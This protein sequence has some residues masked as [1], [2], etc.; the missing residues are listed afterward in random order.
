MAATPVLGRVLSAMVTPMHPDGSLDLQAAARL[1]SHLVDAGHDG[2]VVSGTTG[3]SPTTTDDEKV[4]L[5]RAVVEAVGDRAVVIA[6]VGTNNTAH[7]IECAKAAAGAGADAVLVVT[8]YYNKPPQAGLVAHFTAVA[9]AT[10]LPVMLYDIPGRSGI[11]IAKDTYL[12][13]AK[14]P[15]IVAVKDARADLWLASDLMAATE[16]LWYSGD[17]AMNL[18]HFVNGATGFVG[19]TSQ[20]SPAAYRRMAD[21]VLEGRW[22]D[23]RAIH[24]E[25]IPLVGAVM[26]ITQG[27]IMAKAALALQGIIPS[28]TV[29]L[30]LVEADQ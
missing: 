4:R 29:R 11:A 7:S 10:D 23:A 27:A 16:L 19:V 9:D 6:G 13:V 1:A 21:A 30:P 12:E 3:E 28:P 18:A 8:P 22:D 26:T 2:L 14:H 5:I 15:N 17:D 25:L 20:V 24:R